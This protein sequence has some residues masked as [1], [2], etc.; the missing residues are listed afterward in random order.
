MQY[1]YIILFRGHRILVRFGVSCTLREGRAIVEKTRALLS[2][3][4]FI[5]TISSKTLYIILPILFVII[6]NFWVSYLCLLKPVLVFL[7][8]E[9]ATAQSTDA[10]LHGERGNWYIQACATNG[11]TGRMCREPAVR[12]TGMYQAPPREKVSS[13]SA[14]ELRA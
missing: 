10:C 5:Y 6:L 7:H 9:P 4:W 2:L 14:N 12:A 3:Q 13:L 8:K 1:L 11:S